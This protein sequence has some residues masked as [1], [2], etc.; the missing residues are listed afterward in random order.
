MTVDE[1]VN[2][3]KV[4]SEKNAESNKIST[5]IKGKT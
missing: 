1:K 3:L 2:Y 5:Y 4:E